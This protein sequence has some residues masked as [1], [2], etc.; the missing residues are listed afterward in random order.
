[1]RRSRPATKE[2]D[3]LRGCLG[4]LKA[5]RIDAWRSNSGAMTVP[6]AGGKNRFVRFSG[7]EGLSDI[8]GILPRDGRYLA[9]ECKRP[10]EE[11]THKQARFL[12]RVRASGGVAIVAHSAGELFEALQQLGYGGGPDAA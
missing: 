11:P 7:A 8:T 4:L 2:A 6:G 9:V 5:L 12:N 1:M 3:V 10:G